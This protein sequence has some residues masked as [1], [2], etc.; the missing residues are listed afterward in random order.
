[1]RGRNFSP[2]SAGWR[3]ANNKNVLGACG[4]VHMAKYNISGWAPFFATG[5]LPAGRSHPAGVMPLR[6]LW[7]LG[8]EHGGHCWVWVYTISDQIGAG[9]ALASLRLGWLHFRVGPRRSSLC[10][11]R[12]KQGAFKARL[13][14]FTS[15]IL[16]P[17]SGEPCMHLKAMKSQQPHKPP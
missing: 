17:T 9:P 15:V 11:C 16:G 1:M 10:R 7:P 14:Y 12:A 8:N 13:P 6:L 5:R 2:S 3:D 4:V